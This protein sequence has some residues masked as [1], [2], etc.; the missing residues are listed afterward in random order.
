MGPRKRF[1]LSGIDEESNGAP[2]EDGTEGKVCVLG[3]GRGLYRLRTRG[4]MEQGESR[5]GGGDARD[6]AIE[7]AYVWL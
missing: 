4:K 3:G 7:C 1:T 6:G 5:G 2:E